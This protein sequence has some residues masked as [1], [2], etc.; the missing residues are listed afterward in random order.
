MKSDDWFTTRVMG[1]T[2]AL[3]SRSRTVCTAVTLLSCRY[4]YMLASISVCVTPDSIG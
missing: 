1:T 3:I 4:F 2:A